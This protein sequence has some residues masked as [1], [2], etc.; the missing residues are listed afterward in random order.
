MGCASTK[1]SSSSSK[2][3]KS[4]DSNNGSITVSNETRKAQPS[5]QNSNSLNA[6]VDNEKITVTLTKQEEPVDFDEPIKIN[7][8]LLEQIKSNQEKIVDYIVKIVR[9]KLNSESLDTKQK[10]SFAVVTLAAHAAHLN[11]DLTI[12]VGA[13]AVNLIVDDPNPKYLP[14]SN[15]LELYNLLKKWEFICKNQTNKNRICYLTVE[16][17]R[18]C[19]NEI[20][21]I[22]DTN[23]DLVKFLNGGDLKEENIPLT[24]PQSPTN[25][26]P[27]QSTTNE[28]P[29]TVQLTPTRKIW[30]NAVLLSRN[31]ANELARILF[32]SNRGRPIIHANP[33]GKGYFVNKQLDNNS[34]VTLTQ[35]EIDEILNT[36]NRGIRPVYQTPKLNSTIN[37]NHEPSPNMTI[38]L[39]PIITNSSSTPQITNN[40]SFLTPEASNEPDSALEVSIEQ[41]TGNN[42]E[43][44]TEAII[45]LAANVDKLILENKEKIEVLKNIQH[46]ENDPQFQLNND[47]LDVITNNIEMIQRTN[48][49]NLNFVVENNF[50]NYQINNEDVELN[51]GENNIEKMTFTIN[52][53]TLV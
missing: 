50:E 24:P 35:D 47:I 2:N 41:F 27:P 34:E 39:S 15:Y 9:Q 44:I 12:D 7:K 49:A 42:Q 31:K 22:N 33:N 32:L 29:P 5:A 52:K 38:N 10:L 36:P 26:A 37:F 1:P 28:A 40:L 21:E 48:K 16:T 14:A 4:K 53:E 20:N 13:K 25:E 11:D 6:I 23:F 19:L 17:I 43:V 30:D 18:N 51:E 45:R 3:K 46:N 8:H